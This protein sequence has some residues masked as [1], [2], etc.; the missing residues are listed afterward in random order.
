[1]CVCVEEKRGREREREREREKVEEKPTVGAAGM[2]VRV[3]GE[4]GE[5]LVVVFHCIFL[6]TSSV[7]EV[8]VMCPLHTITGNWW[9]ECL[10]S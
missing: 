6:F 5:S 4:S 8:H 10:P 3:R 7:F 9:T 2:F 1:M